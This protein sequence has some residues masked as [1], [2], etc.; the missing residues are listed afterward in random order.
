MERT[1]HEA[2]AASHEYGFFSFASKHE[3]LKRSKESWNPNKT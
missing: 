1:P 2:G 3:F